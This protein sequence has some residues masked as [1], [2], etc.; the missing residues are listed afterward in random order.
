MTE[1]VPPEAIAW[2]EK[3]DRALLS[4]WALDAADAGLSEEDLLRYWRL[5]ET[6]DEFVRWFAAKYDLTSKDDFAGWP[7]GSSDALWP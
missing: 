7:R 5:G 4:G 3:V 2:I 6:P 1:V